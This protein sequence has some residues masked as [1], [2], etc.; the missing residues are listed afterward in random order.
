MEKLRE[1]ALNNLYKSYKGSYAKDRMATGS[2]PNDWDTRISDFE[3]GAQYANENNP[4]KEENE[5]LRAEKKELLD[6]VTDMGN[7]YANSEWIGG[8]A[9]K[10]IEKMKV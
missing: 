9:K 1:A 5:R 4:L 10:L 2:Y 8:E 6:F 3:K 7:R